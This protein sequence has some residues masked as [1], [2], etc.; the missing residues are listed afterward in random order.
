MSEASRGG[1]RTTSWVRFG[2]VSLSCLLDGV[3]AC[4]GDN[5]NRRWVL[6]WRRKCRLERR[7]NEAGRFLLCSVCDIESKRYCVIFPE[8]RGLL[9]GWNILVEKLHDFEVVSLVKFLDAGGSVTPPGEKGSLSKTYAKMAKPRPGR[10]GDSVW[11]ELGERELL[12]GKDQLDQC[13][14]GWW[15]V[16]FVPTPDL[17]L[18]RSWAS[19]S[20][21]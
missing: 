7:L 16:D 12:G 18:V 13:L 9:G 15:G 10:I 6:D 5:G 14:V 20:G 4:C 1:K 3:E 2:E 17:D 19:T 8:G 21:C 11:L